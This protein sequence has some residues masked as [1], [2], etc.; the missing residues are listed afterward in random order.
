MSLLNL[1]FIDFLNQMSDPRKQAL[2]K[3]YNDHINLFHEARGS[4]VKHQAWAG[5]YADHITE[6]FRVN[7]ATY[8]ALS[9]IRPLPFTQDNAI[10]ALFFH[11]MEK[12]FKYGSDK[13]EDC[14]KFQKM[15]KQG[16]SWKSIKKDILKDM[17]LKYNF[18]FTDDELNALKY[19]HGEGDDYSGE[20]HTACELAAHV[21]HCDNT[22][23]NIWRNAGKG[24]S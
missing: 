5:G 21:H 24:T 1:K 22:S 23:A 18:R 15:H 19:T 7:R 10:I 4:N 2:I 13:H 8:E 20:K 3:I 9:A 17:Q 14:Q 16:A 11:D 6:T 12:P